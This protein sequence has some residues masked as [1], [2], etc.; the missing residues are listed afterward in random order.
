MFDHVGLRVKQF[1]R[2]LAFYSKALTPLGFVA[3]GVD[4]K[5]RS[6]GFGK[7]GE[8]RLWLGVGDA[9]SSVHLAF[10]APNRRAVEKFYAAALETGGRDNGKPG[11]R[12]EYGERYY[13]A[14]ALDPD[15]NNVEAVCIL[16]E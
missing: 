16:R 4:E 2:S 7:E 6:A 13:A 10:V 15:G 3:Q 8:P 5:A 11:L 9:P 1:A 12:P 14:F